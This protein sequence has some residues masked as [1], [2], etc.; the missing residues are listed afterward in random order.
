MVPIPPDFLG[1]GPR[2]QLSIYLFGR[3]HWKELRIQRLETGS[4][5]DGKKERAILPL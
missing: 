5:C 3:G 1:E 2:E 4:G